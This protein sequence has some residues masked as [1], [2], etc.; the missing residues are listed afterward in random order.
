MDRDV[1]IKDDETLDILC[2]EKL[3]LIQKKDGYRFS[4][5]SILISNFVRLK[6]DEKVLEIGSGC[7]VIPIYLSKKGYRNPFVGVEIQGELFS[8]SERN[9]DLNGCDNIHFIHGDI[10]IMKE[11]LKREPF[12]VVIS[13][14]PYTKEKA[15]RKSPKRSKLLARHESTLSASEI[16][17]ISSALLKFLGRLYLVY[18][19]HR[20][21]EIILSGETC[22]L[23]PKRI[24]FVHSRMNEMANLALIE[25][26]KGAKAGLIV[27]KPL[28][29]Y[30]D[31]GY[32][33]EVRSY[34]EL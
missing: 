2:N 6:K 15:G 5:D 11:F 28:Y 26:R 7:G 29:V 33:E 9:R 1:Q 20:L 32:T 21:S 22:G 14:P 3:L 13:N 12:D 10:R 30:E 19:A 31:S 23:E 24:R 25:L 16:M 8:L 18:P 4:I 34:Y 17:E 27:E